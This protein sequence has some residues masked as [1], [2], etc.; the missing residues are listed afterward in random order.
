MRGNVRLNRAF[1]L[2]AVSLGFSSSFQ[3]AAAQEPTVKTSFIRL[4]QGVPG[5]FYEPVQPGPKA[6]IGVFVMHSEGDYLQFSACTELSKRGYSVLCANNST[7]KNGASNDTSID[8]MMLDAKLA[9]AWLR[10]D[11]AIKKVVLLGHSG[12]GVLMSSYEN[13]AE[14]GLKACQGPE[15]ILKCAD[16]L[17]GLPA[18]DGIMLIDSNWGL[19]TMMLFSIDPAV[20]SEQTGQK[21][22][23]DLDLFNTQNGFDPAGAH[24]SDRFVSKFEAAVGKRNNSLVK[25]AL[26]RWADIQAG[27][28]AYNDDDAFVVPGANFLGGDNRLFAQD[29]RIL[30]RT[31]KAWPLLHADGSSTTEI[32]Q[33]ARVPENLKS[34]TASYQAGAL[35]TTVHTFLTTF[36]VRVNDDFRYNEDSVRGVDWSSSYSV[37]VGSVQGISVP[38]LVMGMTG[39]WE[40]SAAESIYQS[41]KSSDKTLAYVEGATHG[42]TTCKKCEKTPGQF[43]DTQ[44]TTYDYVDKWL[45][46]SGRFM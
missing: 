27:K 2:L 20:T 14:N 21:L 38:M 39:H 10:K 31:Q 17:A 16:A 13:I 9:V 6:Q 45:S 1:L 37:P 36:A 35:K 29:V 11:P 40:F 41:A 46:K 43:G 34:L 18:A 24:Y 42:Y 8:R 26:D 44:K 5:V 22:N 32:I 15:K 12:G 25:E 30:S 28:A 4:G 19:P 3:V 23:P 33:T 7:G